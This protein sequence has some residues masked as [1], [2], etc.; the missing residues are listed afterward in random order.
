MVCGDRLHR[1]R[2]LAHAGIGA[3][4]FEEQR[5]L[6]LVLVEFRVTNARV[7]LHIVQELDP[8]DGNADLHRDDDR[9]DRAL[10]IGELADSGGDRLGNSV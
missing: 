1:F 7:H 3:V 4:K 10:E 9:I 8:R 2:L 6:R 5:R